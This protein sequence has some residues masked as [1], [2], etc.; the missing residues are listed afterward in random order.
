[1]RYKNHHLKKNKEEEK[2]FALSLNKFSSIA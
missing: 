1:M 2:R